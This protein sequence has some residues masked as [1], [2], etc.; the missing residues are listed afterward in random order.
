MTDSSYQGK[1]DMVAE[2]LREMIM[3]GQ[4]APGTELRQRDLA[5]YFKVSPTPVR[6]A[7]RRLESE[8]L[9]G[10]ELHRGSR[11]APLDIEQQEENYLILAELEALATRLAVEKMTDDDL[12]E[13]RACG[14]AF[15]AVSGDESE[16]KELNRQFHFR[17]YECARSP[18]LLSLMRVL[19][20]SFAYGPTLWRPHDQSV[21]EHQLLI[22]ALS[23]RD[24]DRAAKSTHDHV[25]GSIEWMRVR[26][27]QDQGP[28]HTMIASGG[29][30]S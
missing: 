27:A 10:T 8:G 25:L 23:A 19:W 18:L 22:D 21:K 28:G 2:T 7:L 6:E 16:A 5:E 24:V 1:S 4:L 17:I 3:T 30:S 26:L 9:V 15:A 11:V 20:S 13:V 14:D 12:A 29:I